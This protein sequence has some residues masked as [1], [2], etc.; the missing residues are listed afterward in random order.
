[1]IGIICGVI[2]H[3]F[4]MFCSIVVTKVAWDKD[5]IDDDELPLILSVFIPLGVMA[6]IGALWAAEVVSGKLP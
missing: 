2:F 5:I 4:L 3:L 1:M 6:F